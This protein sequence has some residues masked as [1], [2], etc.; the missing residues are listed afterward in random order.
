M[1]E[2]GAKA[3]ERTRG[4]PKSGKRSSGDNDLGASRSIKRGKKKR[5][6]DGRKTTTTA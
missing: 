3:T 1:G 6:A 5:G 4:N 2:E